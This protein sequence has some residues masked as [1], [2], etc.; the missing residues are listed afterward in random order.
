MDFHKLTTCYTERGIYKVTFNNQNNLKSDSCI[1]SQQQNVWRSTYKS[2][3][4]ECQDWLW[5]TKHTEINL[6]KG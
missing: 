1:S 6:K 4:K 5:K 2:Q 3:I